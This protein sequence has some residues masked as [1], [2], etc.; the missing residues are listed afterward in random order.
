MNPSN[1]FTHVMLLMLLANVSELRGNPNGMTQVYVISAIAMPLI[2]SL[3]FMLKG[4][5][6]V[7]KDSKPG[8]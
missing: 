3:F 2:Y 1:Y 5:K 7:K 6:D 8:V 4:C